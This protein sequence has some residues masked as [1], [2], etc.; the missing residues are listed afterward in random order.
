MIDVRLCPGRSAPRSLQITFHCYFI[1]WRAHLSED[2]PGKHDPAPARSLEACRRHERADRTSRSALRRRWQSQPRLDSRVS[3]TED[4]LSFG[5]RSTAVGCLC[6]LS[7]HAIRGDWACYRDLAEIGGLP[8]ETAAVLR[9]GHPLRALARRGQ[10]GMLGTLGS[11]IRRFRRVP[12]HLGW[13]FSPACPGRAIVKRCP[14]ARRQRAIPRGAN[15]YP[16]TSSA[17]LLMGPLR[18]E[19]EKA[20]QVRE[21]AGLCHRFW[22]RRRDSN[23]RSRFWPRCSLSRGVPSTSRPRLPNFRSHQG[24]S[25]TRTK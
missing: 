24:G 5:Y 14:R 22:R 9:Q 4:S 3:R 20:P 10:S 25:A 17:F 7:G 11:R 21:L 2:R 6:A 12:K 13:V 23:P 16:P 15:R 1:S 18:T 19:K 8:L